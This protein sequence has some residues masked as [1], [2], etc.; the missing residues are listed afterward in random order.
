MQQSIVDFFE[1]NFTLNGAAVEG[2]GLGD[3]VDPARLYTPANTVPG[4]QIEEILIG[5]SPNPTLSNVI[6][7]NPNQYAGTDT[8]KIVI[9]NTAT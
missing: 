4:H 9:V 1:G 2:F 8:A 7:L 5:L 3:P 6:E